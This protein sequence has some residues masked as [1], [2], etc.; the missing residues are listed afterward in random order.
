MYYDYITSK[1]PLNEDTLA[2]YGVKGMK[3]K[4]R[5]GLPYNSN[6]S[7]VYAHPKQNRPLGRKKNVTTGGTGVHKR[8][9][10]LML[11]NPAGNGHSLPTG[12]NNRSNKINKISRKTYNKV[13]DYLRKKLKTIKK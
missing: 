3:W 8:N 9:E 6:G 13:R 11:H 10:G 1:P 2:H 5:K 12:F 4:R 7:G